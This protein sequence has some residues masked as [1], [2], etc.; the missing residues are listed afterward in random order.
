MTDTKEA[1]ITCKNCGNVFHGEYCNQCGQKVVERVDGSFLW[2]RLR[3]D[4]FDLDRGLLLT[5]R[6]LLTHPGRMVLSYIGGTGTKR[7]YSPLKY[8]AFWT[9]A[10][11][12]LFSFDNAAPSHSIKDLIVNANEP[13]SNGSR[14]DFVSFWTQLI[15]SYPN[16]YFLGFIPFLS[17]ATY[18]FHRSSQFNRTEIVILNSYFAGLLGSIGVI[19]GLCGYLLSLIGPLEPTLMGIFVPIG[20][21]CV[22]YFFL[23]MQKEFFQEKWSITL[24]KGI[25]VIYGGLF[26]Y[27]IALF[28]MFNVIKYMV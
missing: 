26:I 14:D 10:T 2:Q 15:F 1:E 20:V 27:L 8:L 16:F 21:L 19:G 23:K 7:Y 11:L 3:E 25:A 6:E 24:L 18:L 17:I 12:I 4:L 9:T 5:F 28:L 22:L 13:F